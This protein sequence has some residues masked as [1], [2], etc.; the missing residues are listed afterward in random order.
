M[1]QIFFDFKYTQ[2]T[3]FSSHSGILPILF[4]DRTNGFSTQIGVVST[5]LP[6]YCQQSDPN[7]FNLI[8]FYI[9]QG[10]LLYDDFMFRVVY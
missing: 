4:L 2:V 1:Q 8:L 5:Q 6:I 9:S 10:F 3:S 7:S